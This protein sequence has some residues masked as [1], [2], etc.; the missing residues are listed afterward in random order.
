MSTPSGNDSANRPEVTEA[1]PDMTTTPEV[2]DITITTESG[3]DTEELLARLEMA[4]ESNDRLIAQVEASRAQ[5]AAL[6]ELVGRAATQ[7][8][9]PGPEGDVFPTLEEQ[10]R[11]RA[12]G[13]SG[14]RA[15]VVPRSTAMTI[16]MR[17][18]TE[19]VV[20]QPVTTV[21]ARGHPWENGV[22]SPGDRKHYAATIVS[23]LIQYL[24]AIRNAGGAR[25]NAAYPA[26]RWDIW[27]ETG[28]NPT[29]DYCVDLHILTTTPNITEATYGLSMDAS[30]ATRGG[31]AWQY[32]H[33]DLPHLD[34][35]TTWHP[36]YLSTPEDL[37]ILSELPISLS[38]ESRPYTKSNLP[39]HKGV[40]HTHHG[41]TVSG[42]VRG[43]TDDFVTFVRSVPNEHS[44]RALFLKYTGVVRLFN[45]SRAPVAD[46]FYKWAV[47]ILQAAQMESVELRQE[48][49]S[50]ILG[51]DVA[52]VRTVL[53]R[54]SPSPGGV[55]LLTLSTIG[56]LRTSLS[57]QNVA[58]DIDMVK[59][60]Q[61]DNLVE[62][63]ATR[64][65]L[66]PDPRGLR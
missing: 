41:R 49:A 17:Q 46:K 35:C 33:S 37:S 21:T 62:Y 63:E 23:I 12:A 11:A 8:A 30:R 19:L 22:L 40:F 26:Q 44:C 53:A 9:G 20:P 56:A 15:P 43:S 10:V 32:E 13:P 61:T 60:G 48:T 50:R 47:T 27:F 18:T 31:Q 29:H 14:S 59:W 25:S 39:L 65:R 55:Y 7:T 58:H 66:W 24:D 6:E 28:V 42:F 2:P 51:V 38:R 54:F 52:T 36:H 34:E 16:L 3:P 1:P 45:V 4:L 57:I 64:C 5:Y